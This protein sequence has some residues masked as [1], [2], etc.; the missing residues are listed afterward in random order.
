MYSTK[1]LIFVN[2]Y[3]KVYIKKTKIH[4]VKPYPICSSRLA[5]MCVRFY[6]SKFYYYDP[7]LNRWKQIP[8]RVKISALNNKSLW[9]SNQASSKWQ[10]NE[11]KPAK[12][13]IYMNTLYCTAFFLVNPK[14]NM[15]SSPSFPNSSETIQSTGPGCW[16]H[17]C[18]S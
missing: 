15:S 18:L 16:Q 10:E 6:A 9:A 11:N 1:Y 12:V 7:R 17:F 5:I 14:H 3:Q 2:F 4:N 8:Q 13:C